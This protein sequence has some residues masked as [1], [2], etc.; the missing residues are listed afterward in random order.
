MTVTA[1]NYHG[2][3]KWTL[4]NSRGLKIGGIG[5]KMCQ[6]PSK[7]RYFLFGGHFSG[8]KTQFYFPKVADIKFYEQ[9]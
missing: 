8:E 7:T 1:F 4:K 6:N 3:G 5:G 2:D 9:F